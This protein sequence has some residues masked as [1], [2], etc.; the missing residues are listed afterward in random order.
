MLQFFHTIRALRRLRLIR[1]DEEWL[2]SLRRR[3][4]QE[5]PGYAI[6]PAVKHRSLKAGFAA[7]AVAC[8][9][10]FAVGAAVQS[11]QAAAPNDVLYPIKLLAEKFE[12][13][14]V[15]GNEGRIDFALKLAER[16]LDEVEKLGGI[17]IVRGAGTTSVATTTAGTVITI[18]QGA[19][20]TPETF[21]TGTFFRAESELEKAQALL[22]DF[23]GD[24][25]NSGRGR[26]ESHKGAKRL[27]KAVKRVEKV[28]ERRNK[29]A[30]K[31][32][33]EFPKIARVAADAVLTASGG[34]VAITRSSE[35]MMTITVASGAAAS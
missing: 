7:A 24:H 1:P 15:V 14:F 8:L 5:H 26:G 2:R 34:S 4:V 17:V 6:T 19:S 23:A 10:I 22:A 29:L 31:L 18:G 35:G 11:A 32:N 12:S 30:E 33:H 13:F 9:V 3:L 28:L 20:S 25:G 27:E 16:R 21:I